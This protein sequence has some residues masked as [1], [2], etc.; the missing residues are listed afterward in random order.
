[1]MMPYVGR[2]G[3][4]TIADR[5]RT[6]VLAC[7]FTAVACGGRVSIGS[8]AC[9]DSDS[10]GQSSDASDA[11]ACSP[12]PCSIIGAWQNRGAEFKCTG[13]SC[14]QVVPPCTAGAIRFDP[15]GAM[16]WLTSAGWE[17][18]CGFATCGDRVT[19]SQLSNIITANYAATNTC[20]PNWDVSI[21]A[22]SFVSSSLD[23]ASTGLA[24]CT[25]H[26]SA[27]CDGGAPGLAPTSVELAYSSCA[28]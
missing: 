11:V 20:G 21:V 23:D 6:V 25:I 22:S 15:S 3:L 24:T 1:M 16:F 2:E 12:A 14:T 26:A 17:S 27:P 28:P 19:G 4:D 18:A 9:D 7:C 5:W 13:Q 8:L 10:G